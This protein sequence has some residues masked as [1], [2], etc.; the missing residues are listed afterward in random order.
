MRAISGYHFDVPDSK[1]I[2]LII[3]TDA[4]AEADDQFAIVH[5]LLTPRFCIKGIV[6]AHFGTGRT[7]ESV[8][9]SYDE[10]LKLLSL[11]DMEGEVDV[12]RG[13]AKALDESTPQPSE[14][15]S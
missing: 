7:E 13:A 9:E 3:D 11:M 14:G 5:A 1:K 15:R 12:Y 2:R 6:A 4:K 10:V 8:E